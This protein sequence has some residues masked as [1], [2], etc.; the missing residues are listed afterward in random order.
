[1]PID[2]SLVV[3]KDGILRWYLAILAI[4]DCEVR[5]RKD[6]KLTGQTEVEEN[7]KEAVPVDAAAQEIEFYF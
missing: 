4:T 5:S 1:M 2:Y 7:T 6:L 3:H